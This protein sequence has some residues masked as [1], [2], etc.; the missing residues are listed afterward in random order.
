[1]NL[2]ICSCTAILLPVIEV[3]IQLIMLKYSIQSADNQ[4]L[5]YDINEQSKI[6]KVEASETNCSLLLYVTYSADCYEIR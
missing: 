6:C 3:L 4:H 2:R 5:I 1:M